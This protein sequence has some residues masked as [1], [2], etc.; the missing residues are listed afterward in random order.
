MKLINKAQT[1]RFLIEYAKHNRHHEFTQVSAETL[2]Q[3]EFALQ[4]WLQNHVM[5]A[6]S[7]GKTL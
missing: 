5:A 2:Q 4:R 7:K 3:A 6:P 1:K